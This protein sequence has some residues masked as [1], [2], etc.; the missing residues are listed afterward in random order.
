MFE[1]R[2]KNREQTRQVPHHPAYRLHKPPG[3]PW[4]I[5]LDPDAPLSHRQLLRHL[6]I[7]ERH[8]LLEECFAH[9]WMAIVRVGSVLRAEA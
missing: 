2:K 5:K 9:S 6:D 1:V 3:G 8:G 4:K 7:A